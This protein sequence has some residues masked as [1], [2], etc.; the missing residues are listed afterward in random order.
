[1]ISIIISTHGE[2]AKGLLSAVKLIA[3]EQEKMTDVNFVTGQGNDELKAN[4]KATIDDLNT[5]DVLIM[6]DLAGG[7]PYNVSS[8]LANDATKQNIAVISGVNLPM[9]L[10]AAFA[11]ETMPLD[12]LTKD[13]LKAARDGIKIY[14]QKIVDFSA[15]ADADGI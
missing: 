8:L 10:E 6:T 13:I 11:R 12:E 4:L 2:F 3:G 15:D 1:M 7:S 14:E 9:A 5:E